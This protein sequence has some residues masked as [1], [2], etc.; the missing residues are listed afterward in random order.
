M[1][2]ASTDPPGARPS[3][4]PPSGLREISI[5]VRWRQVGAGRLM[6]ADGVAYS[7]LVLEDDLPTSPFLALIG[8]RVVS[9]DPAGTAVVEAVPAQEHLNAVGLVH[10]GYISALLDATTGIAIRSLAPVGQGTPHIQSDYRFLGGV[11]PGARLRC[12]ACVL[13][14]GRTVSHVD[15]TVTDSAGCLV[16]VGRT[17]H[18][19]TTRPD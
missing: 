9:I 11:R 6:K 17:T 19:A 12:R 2:D 7:A 18:V 8:G 14:A 16:A 5:G 3:P 4:A 15:S 13:H 1:A 10:G